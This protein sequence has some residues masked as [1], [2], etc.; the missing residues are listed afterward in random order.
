MEMEQ[1]LEQKSGAKVI[2]ME[3]AEKIV[4]CILHQNDYNRV[5]SA[6]N[7]LNVDSRL[8]KIRVVKQ[9]PRNSTGKVLYEILQKELNVT[10]CY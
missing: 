2:C 5:L 7:L 10:N 4:V 9:I 1:L 8:L 6:C 3:T